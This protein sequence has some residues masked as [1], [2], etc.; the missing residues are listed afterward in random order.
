ML[1]G[2]GVTADSAA[3]PARSPIWP[4][5]RMILVL[6]LVAAALYGVVFFIKK[7]GRKPEVQDQNLKVL[8]GVHLGSNRYAHVISL[9]SK[10]WLVGTADGGVNLIAEIDEKEILDSMLL[11][12]SKKSV[13]PGQTLDFK[14][15]LGRLGLQ[16]KPPQFGADKIRKRRDRLKG[17]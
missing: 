3:A 9:G 7:A 14:A 8:A 1:I 12:A 2:D 17:W 13:I 6:A 11:D 15:I 10:A 16:I 5:V 4:V